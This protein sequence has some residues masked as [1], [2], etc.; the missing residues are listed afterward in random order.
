MRILL[1]TQL[2]LWAA[3]M[4]DRLSK[5]AVRAIEDQANQLIFSAASIHEVAIKSGLG[6]SEFMVKPEILLR[7][8]LKSGYVELPV[9][10]EHA[11]MVF[12]LPPIHR[13]PFDRIMIAQ[14]MCEGV[15]F[16]TADRTLGGYSDVV[17][18]V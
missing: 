16:F 17:H 1:D 18:I 10:S 12:Q 7:G 2:L 6:R 13:D 15:A 5:G 11:A 4:P 8:L 3:G 9:K 14:A